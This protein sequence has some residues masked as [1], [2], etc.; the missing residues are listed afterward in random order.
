[1]TR[2]NKKR[3]GDI[4]NFKRGYDLPAHR[5]GEGLY[6]V[7]SSSGISG[8]HSEY[9]VEGEGVITGRYGTLGEVYYVNGKYW[10]HNTALY[11]T[12]FKG[13]FPKYVYYLLSS[14][15]KMK[16]SDKSTVPGVN[17]NELHELTVPY[18]TTD[19]QINIASVLSALDAKIEVNNRINA[20]LDTIAKTVYDYWFMQFDFPNQNGKPYKSSGGK[21]E[22]NA[23]LKREIP[24]GW[25]VKTLS[26][27]IGQDKTGDWGKDEPEGNYTL[28][29]SCIR[30][31]DIN[32]LNG[33]GTAKPPTRLILE[34]NAN[35]ILSPY[36]IIIEISGGSPTQSTGRLAFITERTS[37]RFSNPL[38]CSN[39]CKALSLKQ[40]L[41]VYWFI[42]LWKSVY[43]N[44]ILFNWEGKTSGIKNLLFEAFSEHYRVP[45]PPD[46]IAQQFSSCISPLQEKK[47]AILQENQELAE[48]RD[49][50]LP[51]L[52]NGQV[53]VEGG[54]SVNPQWLNP[55][56]ID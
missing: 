31:T 10:P 35:K 27:L 26:S 36:D 9:K 52:I 22:Y 48:L 2:A 46:K 37:E 56:D 4:L 25:E 34:K 1:M 13:N 15:G 50:L 24:F 20:E 18:I 43:D 51:M 49:W 7:I 39:F 12:D 21:M 29:V 5:R 11:V 16:P 19:K 6:P 40:N 28:Q 41:F 8:Y 33:I 3:L 44:G 38:I 45:L 55:D 47:D 54:N 23:A 30:G 42:Y 32:G 53:T 14:L 17:R